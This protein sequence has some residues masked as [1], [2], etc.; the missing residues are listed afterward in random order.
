MNTEIPTWPAQAD[1]ERMHA[2]TVAGIQEHRRSQRR[3]KI[4]AVAVTAV[5]AMGFT[6]GTVISL[7]KGDVVAGPATTTA[8]PSHPGGPYKID[9][10]LEA[11]NGLSYDYDPVRLPN[12]LA[13]LSEL[14]VSGTVAGFREGRSLALAGNYP[15]DGSRSVVLV[16]THVTAARGELVDGNDGRIYVELRNPGHPDPSFYDKAFPSGAVVVAYLVPAP[17]GQPRADIDVTAASRAAGVPAGQT[18]YLPANPQ[19]LIMQFSG[20][21]VVWP[22]IG[23]HKPGSIAETLPEGDLIAE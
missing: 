23:A 22:L 2:A 10:T 14:V 11:F 12:Q 8:Q 21:D 15:A 4:A 6:A 19:G 16:L 20:E 1:L 18:L 3:S 13:E 7:P 5:L 9:D 17:A